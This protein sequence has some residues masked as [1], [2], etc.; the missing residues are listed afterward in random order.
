MTKI[1]AGFLLSLRLDFSA[2]ATAIRVMNISCGNVMDDGN[3]G[4]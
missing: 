4:I 1:G 2:S 3:S